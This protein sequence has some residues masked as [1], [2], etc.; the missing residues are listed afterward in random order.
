MLVVE[1]N[2]ETHDGN[3]QAEHDGGALA[4]DQLGLLTY[5]QSFTVSPVGLPAAPI[6]EIRNTWDT[7]KSKGIY[8]IV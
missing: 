3:V 5:L 7:H 6:T 2:R 1:N 8:T 4:D